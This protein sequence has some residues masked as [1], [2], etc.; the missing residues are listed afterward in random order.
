MVLLHPFIPFFTEKV[1]QEFNFKNYFKSALMLKNW[2]L[3]YYAQFKKSHTEIDWLI[4]IVTSIRST[5]VDLNVPPGTFIDI[6]VEELKSKKSKIIHDNS[7]VLKRLGRISNIDYSKTN[8]NG[9]KI[10]IDGETITL[11]FSQSLNLQEQFQRISNKADAL[12]KKINQISN[13]LSNK[14]FL[15]NA[16]KQ[17]INNEK[18]VLE[19]CE[20]ELKKLNSI[21]NS[22]KN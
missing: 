10:V 15:K 11:Y 20:L 3:K 8:K 21:L 9:V 6:S 13:K 5:K 19:D 14:S 12:G 1:W 4:K 18:K 17:I 22:I 2:D 7:I 16:P